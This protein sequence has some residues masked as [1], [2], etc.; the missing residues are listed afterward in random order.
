MIPLKKSAWFILLLLAIG[1][2]K[3]VKV[4]E[5]EYPTYWPKPN[6]DI[7]AAAVDQAKINLGR[8]LFYDRALSGNNTISCASCHL[9]FTSFTHTDHAISHGINDE[10]GTRNS[11][12]LVN[13]AWNKSFMWDGAINHLD[14]Q[15]LAPI[16]SPSE[17]G[18]KI[19]EVA[20]RLENTTY[21]PQL[22]YEA[23]KDSTI[24]GAAILKALA[25][26]QLTMISANSKYDKYIAGKIE[27]NTEEQHGEE[28][29]NT[30]CA[31]CHE[32]P[33]FTTHQFANNGLL[34]DTNLRDYGR[35]L[36]SQNTADSLQFR[37]PTLRNSSYTFPYMHDGRFKTLIQ[38]I[39]FY[40]TQEEKNN[41]VDHRIGNG[42]QLSVQDKQALLAFIKT[43]DDP[44]Y[45]KNP[46]LGYPKALVEKMGKAMQSHY[47]RQPRTY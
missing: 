3:R 19:T 10:Q 26:F 8:I 20:S 41:L 17:M 22:F 5:P 11:I 47:N 21:Y 40:T 24:S 9:I 38:V 7:K 36:I 42:F 44:E 27:L 13:L 43:L 28:L 34:V 31:T 29:F 39:D 45:I 6:Y 37:I 32:P 12:A 23:F 14:F 46:D 1:C 16:E 33:L 2:Q 30:H 25:A 15:G 35:A 18:S 4:Y